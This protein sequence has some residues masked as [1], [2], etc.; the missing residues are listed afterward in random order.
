MQATSKNAKNTISKQ[1][2][3]VIEELK[4]MIQ[5]D[6]GNIKFESFDEKSGLVTVTLFGACIGCPASAITLQHG[7]L[8]RLKEEFPEVKNV[9][10]SKES[11]PKI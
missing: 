5:A 6:G 4:P 2:E 8:A 11:F 1:I 3:S 9:V 10:L 7:V